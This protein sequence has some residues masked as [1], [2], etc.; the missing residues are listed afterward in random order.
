MRAIRFE[1]TGGPNVLELVE[2]D[3]PEPKPGQVLIRHAAIGVNFIETYQR[4][5]L[6]P[7][8][9]PSGLGGEA[10]G[11]VEAVGDGVTRFKVG[12]RVATAGSGSPGAYA[13]YSVSHAERAWW[14]SPTP[15]T[16]TPPRPPC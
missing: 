11:V 1:T 7:M 8:K 5:G 15:S 16:S 14:P 6:Y 12:D 13:D 2:I 9:L 4:S 3:R 10:A